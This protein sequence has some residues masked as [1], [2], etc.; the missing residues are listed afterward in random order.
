MAD[1]QIPTVADDTD[2]EGN[3]AD[4]EEPEENAISHEYDNE[5]DAGESEGDAGDDL[6]DG[7]EDPLDGD[8]D[9]EGGADGEISD[10][11]PTPEA[12]TGGESDE[13]DDIDEE[14][15]ELDSETA[16]LFDGVDSPSQSIDDEELD[17]ALENDVV[18][19]ALEGESNAF[20]N[21]Y[22]E[23]MAKLT[24]IGLD[25]NEKRGLEDD[26]ID[27]FETFRVDYFASRVWEEKIMAEHDTDV[28]PV[29]GLVATTVLCIAYGVYM[30]PD[31]EEQVERVIQTFKQD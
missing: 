15:V 29:W 30:R 19:G 24:L 14:F 26:L 7:V 28:N 22:V 1:N 20:G 25:Q 21:A 10:E 23:G 5:T 9:T 18:T 3:E 27:T 31:S 6:F 4:D 12:D 13:K 11:T 16:D 2:D 17:E 8:I